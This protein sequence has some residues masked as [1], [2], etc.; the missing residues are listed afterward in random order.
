MTDYSYLDNLIS[1]VNE[2][3][4]KMNFCKIDITKCE[5]SYMPTKKT[6]FVG[7]KQ[8]YSEQLIKI[9]NG[10]RE[11]DKLRSTTK[12]YLRFLKNEDG[13]IIQIE[14]YKKGSLDCLFQVYWCENLR[15]LLP[16]SSEGGF[17]PTYVYVTKYEENRVVE[18]YMVQ[19]KQIVYETYGLI[20][21]GEAE[22]SCINY[23]SGGDYP[24][25]EIK[26]GKY[27]FDPLAYVE[28]YSDN[29]LN[30]RQRN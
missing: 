26:K 25:R 2:L 7:F 4:S 8:G 18:E 11:S 20:I 28:N 14:N 30:Y 13:E 24:V 19:G 17:Y 1:E 12:D 5:I 10:M 3:R 21:N 29:W 27:T 22:Y 9:Q 15:Y 16:Y 23:V 6:S